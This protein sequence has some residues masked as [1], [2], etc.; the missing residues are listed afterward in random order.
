M[1]AESELK[2]GEGG[3]GDRMAHQFAPFKSMNGF[4]YRA[5]GAGRDLGNA[6][7]DTGEF[8]DNVAVALL[9]SAPRVA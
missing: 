5:N 9:I 4:G 1:K 3:V 7:R 2:D 6:S 8:P